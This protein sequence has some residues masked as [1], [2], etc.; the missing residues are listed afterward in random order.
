MARK[1]KSPKRSTPSAADKAR[2][3]D[4]RSALT[5]EANQFLMES[6][7]V[8]DPPDSDTDQ[9]EEEDEL[10]DIVEFN[11]SAPGTLPG[12]LNIPEDA[13]PTE[14]VLMAYGPN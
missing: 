4:R 6:P 12:T 11:Y 2:L 14:L 10:D 3:T 9:D 13:L 8:P 5:L 1:R 7:A